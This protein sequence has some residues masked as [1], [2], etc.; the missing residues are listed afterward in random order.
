MV[1]CKTVISSK[2][3]RVTINSNR[4]YK[5]DDKMNRISKINVLGLLLIMFVEISSFGAQLMATDDTRQ[6]NG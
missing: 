2:F 4:V 5:T 1:T 6:C 3:K